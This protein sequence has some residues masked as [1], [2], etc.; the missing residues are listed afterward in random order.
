MDGPLDAIRA[1]FRRDRL[2]ELAAAVVDG[3]REHELLLYASAIS[4]RVL[5]ALPPLLLFSFGLLGFLSLDE[6]WR[7]DIA[8]DVKAAVS[9]DVFKVLDDTVNRVIGDK[10]VFWATGGAL[11]ALWE[12]SGGVRITMRALN[13]IYEVDEKRDLK[14]QF[15]LSFAL[16]AALTVLVL[17]AI[18]VVKFG[19]FLFDDLLGDGAAVGALS[20]LV[21]WAAA[22]ALLFAAMA[23]VLRLGPSRERPLAWVSFGAALAVGSWVAMSLLFGLYLSEIADYGSV[24]GNLATVFVLIEYLYLSGLAFVT[25]LLVDAQTRK[26]SGDR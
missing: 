12:V 9:A 24:F 1:A 15:A 25:G 19:P 4:F 13:R 23:L 16:A 21:R 7:E 10:Q 6:V 3:F 22:V 2:R 11:L 17:S 14:E 5:L 8:P 20:I 18:A 26:R